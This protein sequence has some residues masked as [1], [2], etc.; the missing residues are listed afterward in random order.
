MIQRE[1]EWDEND[2]GSNDSTDS[3]PLPAS[4]RR[5][6]RNS[7]TTI[8]DDSDRSSSS[9]S[10]AGFQKTRKSQLVEF[11]EYEPTAVRSSSGGRRGG[12]ASGG[13]G[14]VS[15]NW[16]AGL[17]SAGF[18][19][20]GNSGG[21]GS[22]YFERTSSE[23]SPKK[24]QKASTASG[25]PTNPKTR[26]GTGT[27]QGS[28]VPGAL[29]TLPKKLA[30]A[31]TT[32][33]AAALLAPTAGTAMAVAATVKAAPVVHEIRGPTAGLSEALLCVE[34]S[35]Q[36]A[37]L[38][39]V[40]FPRWAENNCRMLIP[41]SSTQVGHRCGDVPNGGQHGGQ[42]GSVGLARVVLDWKSGGA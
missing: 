20:K 12:D 37:T 42:S 14:S 7:S 13:S 16:M 26:Q 9:S 28:D 17:E 21:G 27:L 24:Q 15:D 29:T 22:V 23:P 6:S 11:D 36:V 2:D 39:E 32:T 8:H 38:L 25:T 19:V 31:A 30:A 41:G 10:N 3:F 1:E 5:S 34:S 18:S 33:R 4:G 35:D 40:A